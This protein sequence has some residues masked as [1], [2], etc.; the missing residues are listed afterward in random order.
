MRP[1]LHAV[2]VY[3]V[4]VGFCCFSGIP[5]HCTSPLNAQLLRAVN[6]GQVGQVRDLLRRGAN[7]NTRY[8]RGTQSSTVLMEAAA[9]GNFPIVQALLAREAR[10]NARGY[11]CMTG[12]PRGEG[13]YRQ[14]TALI[15]A[16]L[17]G[18]N[19]EIVSALLAH[20]A[21]VNAVDKSG[22]TALSNSLWLSNWDQAQ[23]LLAH[24]AHTDRKTRRLIARHLT[25][26][27]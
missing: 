7:P 18:D 2:L 25:Q 17:R 3:A 20:G 19:D 24:G 21:D 26:T 15:E 22:G 4:L 12:V 5:G 11:T 9:L 27:G 6:G 13:D 8:Y 10:V 1:L 14:S 23:V 16:C